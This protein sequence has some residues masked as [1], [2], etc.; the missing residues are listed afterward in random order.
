MSICRLVYS[1]WRFRGFMPTGNCH[2][3]WGVLPWIDTIAP[4]FS[5]TQIS[6]FLSVNTPFVVDS[7]ITVGVPM[8]ECGA[9]LEGQSFII[10]YFTF[11][12]FFWRLFSARTLSWVAFSLNDQLRDFMP[13]TQCLPS[14]SGSTK[15]SGSSSSFLGTTD[16]TG[17]KGLS[18]LIG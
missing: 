7:K 3:R 13:A 9:T 17:S 5:S 10:I 14:A 6:H 11:R 12:Q 8:Y 15:S 16:S 4:K 1:Q 2:R 18:K